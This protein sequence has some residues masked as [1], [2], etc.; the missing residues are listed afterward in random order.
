M[1]SSSLAGRTEEQRSGHLDG[2]GRHKSSKSMR[3]WMRMTDDGGLTHLEVGGQ[4]WTRPTQTVLGG[5]T[6]M[7]DG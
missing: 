4:W 1:V 6:R 7:V 2:Y 5:P 3:W